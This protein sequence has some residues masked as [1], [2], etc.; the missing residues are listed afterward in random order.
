M[1]I[2]GDFFMPEIVGSGLAVF[3]ADGDDD[4]DIYALQ[5]GNHLEGG[6]RDRLLLQQ[7]DGRFQEAP[8]TG[9]LAVTG[10]GMGVA[11]GDI[12][13]DGDIDLY[14]GN[15]GKDRLLINN[16]DGTFKDGSARAGLVEEQWTS[17]VAFV[18]INVDGF[19][20]IYVSHYLIPKKKACFNAAGEPDYCGPS[21]YPP[22]R[23]LILI[24]KRNGRF[25][26]ASERMGIAATILPGLGVLIA[27]FD[28]D[29]LPDVYV[30]NDGRRNLA[31]MNKGGKQLRDEAFELGL[32]VNGEGNPEASMGLT[33]GDVDGDGS[34]DLF[35]THL[36]E[37][38]H[39]LYRCEGGASYVD[40][41]YSWGLDT[42]HTGFGTTF[43]DMDNDGDLDLV[44]ANGRVKSEDPPQPGRDGFNRRYGD[45][46][47]LLLN[48]DRRFEDV[49]DRTGS[50]HTER[51]V[52]RGLAMVD[53]DRDGDLDIIISNCSSRLRVYR[54]DMESRGSWI[55]VRAV[56]PALG[57]RDV[58]G[59]VVEVHAG[60]RMLKGMIGSDRSYQTSVLDAHHFG[61]GDAARVDRFVVTWPG[62]RSE[63]F[64]GCA[65]GRTIKLERGK[66]RSK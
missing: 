3:D 44:V 20:D 58:L 2:R 25:E 42:D 64:D 29:G 4:L 63:N 18:D 30:A 7:D 23:D 5:A 46:N 60:G 38:S 56:D 10:Y 40:V 62:G 34:L 65:A 8:A 37:E 15:F 21:S 55:G 48:D 11:A 26:D 41:T 13:N 57:G 39:T 45:F 51:E 31:W 6:A 16:G 14:V 66:G 33:L 22:R 28:E 1:T 50:F 43:A 19:L 9:G 49:S 61:L 54:N 32:A 47:Q 35:M 12:D 59:A 17:S 27:D 36:A 24:N 52:S 53:L